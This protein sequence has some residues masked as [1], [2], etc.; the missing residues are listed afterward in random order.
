M[1]AQYSPA[2]SVGEDIF[3]TTVADIRII[4]GFKANT[5]SR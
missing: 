3:A 4:K 5:R 1:N 2:W